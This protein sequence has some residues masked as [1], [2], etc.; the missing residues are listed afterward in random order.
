MEGWQF[1]IEFHKDIPQ[2][3]DS[4]AALQVGLLGHHLFGTRMACDRILP[5]LT[6]PIL[7][8]WYVSNRLHCNIYLIIMIII[9]NK[10]NHYHNIL[11]PGRFRQLSVNL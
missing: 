7:I 5:K 8:A 1:L 10:N 6:K 9:N 4:L 2:V 3:A 11:F